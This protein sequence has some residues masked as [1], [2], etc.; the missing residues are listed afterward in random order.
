MLRF[1]WSNTLA[2]LGVRY[3]MVFG[4]RLCT[5]QERSHRMRVTE[6]VDVEDEVVL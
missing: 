2:Y 6:I 5:A 3:A 4:A 1:A